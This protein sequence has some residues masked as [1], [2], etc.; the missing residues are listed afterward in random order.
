M[1]AK[2]KKKKKNRHPTISVQV[3]L[4][5]LN[6][7]PVHAF[8]LFPMNESNLLAVSRAQKA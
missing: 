7:L 6:L 3:W 4:F 5:V 1:G 2:K 8:K